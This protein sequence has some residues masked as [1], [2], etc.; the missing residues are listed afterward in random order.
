MPTMSDVDQDPVPQIQDNI[1]Y[2]QSSTTS[3]Q[4]DQGRYRESI[5]CSRYH[6]WH[7]SNAS[8]DLHCREGDGDQGEQRDECH[9][10]AA[11][12]T[13]V[14]TMDVKVR[15]SQ[16]VQAIDL[17]E[18]AQA[19]FSVFVAVMVVSVGEV[20]EDFASEALPLLPF[21]AL[22]DE[23]VGFG[24]LEVG[25][26]CDQT[27]VRQQEAACRCVDRP[28]G[29]AADDFREV[30]PVE[31][32]VIQPFDVYS[33]FIPYEVKSCPFCEDDVSAYHFLVV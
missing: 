25:R 31:Q 1:Q 27:G 9:I 4:R 26:I 11:K 7:I 28:C 29:I 30:L 3:S 32:L 10:V 20:V 17:V 23:T 8:H 2:E 18:P 14:V 33:L 6:D 19:K 15:Q 5:R 12:V 21:D 22:V 24:Y 13:R 16:Q